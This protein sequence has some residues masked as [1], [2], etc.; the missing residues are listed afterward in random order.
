M[1]A[2]LRFAQAEGDADAIR[3]GTEILE[4]A[5]KATEAAL[6]GQDADPHERDGDTSPAAGRGDSEKFLS[7]LPTSKQSQ[8]RGQAVEDIA[9]TS[10]RT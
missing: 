5:G 10:W 8:L 7:A 2:L 4:M 9:P 6:L 1:E 3:K